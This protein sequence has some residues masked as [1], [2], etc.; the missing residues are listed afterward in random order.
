MELRDNGILEPWDFVAI[1]RWNHDHWDHDTFGKRD[2][3]GKESMWRWNPENLRLVTL[4]N[5]T[6]GKLNFGTMGLWVH[7]TLEPWSFETMGLWD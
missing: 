6:V 1:G 4:Y 7:V 3:G 2:F 5:G